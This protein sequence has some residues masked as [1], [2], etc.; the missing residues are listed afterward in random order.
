M[1]YSVLLQIT[2]FGGVLLNTNLSSVQS[3][4]E[5]VYH[6]KG[7]PCLQH[8]FRSLAALIFNNIISCQYNIILSC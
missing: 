5:L 1:I 4:Q 3:A 6:S 8:F 2:L 7:S